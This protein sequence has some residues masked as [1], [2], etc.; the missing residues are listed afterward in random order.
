MTVADGDDLGSKTK[1]KIMKNLRKLLITGA[2]ALLLTTLAPSVSA[3][4]KAE[5]AKPYPL[6]TCIV[7]DEKLGGMGEAYVFTYQGQEIKLCCQGCKKQFDKEPAKYLKKLSA[8]AKGGHS[9]HNH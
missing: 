5:K 1:Q 3:A 7:S 2:S 6:Q 4:E 9:S 8:D